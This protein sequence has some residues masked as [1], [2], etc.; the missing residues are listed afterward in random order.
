M[1]ERFKLFLEQ[2][3]LREKHFQCVLKS[4]DLELQIYEAKLSQSK[5]I[6]EEDQA[7]V[8][9]LKTELQQSLRAENESR[10][11]LNIYMEKFKGVEKSLSDSSDMFVVLRRDLD[12]VGAVIKLITAR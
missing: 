11:Q 4:K 7:T 2:Y 5:E 8:S 3:E 6:V 10:K 12:Q 1:K 9:T